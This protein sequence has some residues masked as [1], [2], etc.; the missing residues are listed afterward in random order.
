MPQDVQ[1]PEHKEPFFERVLDRH[2]RHQ[3]PGDES[4]D[5]NKNRH[6]HE[7]RLRNDLK[8][9]ESGLKEYFEEDEELEREGQ[10]YGGLM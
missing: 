9:D 3:Q 6:H 5:D 4:K 10:T 1:E 8:K 2:H 7:N